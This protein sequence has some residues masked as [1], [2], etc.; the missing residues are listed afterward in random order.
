MKKRFSFSR[1]I[2]NDKLMMVLSL[3]IAVVIWVTVLTGPMNIVDRIVTTKVTVNLGNSYAGLSGLRVIGEDEI[4][5]Q[6]TIEGAWSVI[7][8]IDGEDLRVSADLTAITGPG[9][10]TLPLLVSR[11]SAETNYDILSVTPSTMTVRCDY[12]Q[13]GTIFK[14]ESDVSALTVKDPATTQI[15]EPVIDQSAFSNGMVTIEGPKSTVS[16]IKQVV[17]R[18]AATAEP[19]S[20]I[21]QFDVPLTALDAAGNPVDL[22]YCTFLEVPTGIVR[23]TVPIWE[24]RQIKLGFTAINVPAG[25]DVTSL[26]TVEPPEIRV[27]GPSAELDALEAQL[28][29]IGTVDLQTL[30][31]DAPSVSFPLSLPSTVRGVEIPTNAVVKLN[32]EAVAQTTLAVTANSENVTVLGLKN[33]DEATVSSHAFDDIVFVGSPTAIDA[34]KTSHVRFT[35]QLEEAYEDEAWYTPLITVEGVDGVWVVPD[36][37]L[38][39]EKIYVTIK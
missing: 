20:T 8:R 19:L 21:R 27:L 36:E 38:S 6:V 29:T 37:E 13:E 15:G 12:W 26:L 32:E 22:T 18:V 31:A 9:D 1:L 14:V 4:D 39:S 34:L 10:V 17:A 11:N 7:S 5:V 16:Q 23:M 33:G 24:S 28:Q 35:V 2:Y 25:M 3:L 30:S